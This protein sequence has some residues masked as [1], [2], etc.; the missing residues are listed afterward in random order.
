MIPHASYSDLRA[1]WQHNQ[2]FY[3]DL[4]RQMVAVNSFSLNPSGVNALGRLTA[5][6]F[7]PLGFQAE[8]IPSSDYRY[9]HHL[10]LTRA[11]RERAARPAP[12]IG[13]IS[14]LDTVFP[15]AEEQA[16]DFHFRIEGDRVYGP[17]TVDIKG[18]T[19]M[20]YMILDGLR[21]AFPH[22]YEGI[23]W[24]ILLNA[25]EEVLAP[26]F[27]RLGRE[28]L[29]GALAALV[30]EGGDAAD[31]GYKL[32]TARKGMARYRVRV[33]GRSA[34]AGTSHPKGANAIVQLADV[35]HAIAELTDHSREL[36][37]N[38]GTVAGGT[39]MN[40]VPHQAAASVEMRAYDQNVFE[41]G[42]AGMLALN[43]YCSVRSL[44][45][46]YPCQVEVE[47]EGRWSP[48][49]PNEATNR[50]VDVWAAAA[51]DLGLKIVSQ[52]RGGLSDGNWLWD[53]LPTL[54]GLGPQ[55]DNA[56]SSERS[57]D[58]SKEPE[59]VLASSFMPK[60]LLN[61]AAIV[62][63]AESAGLLPGSEQ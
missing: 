52:S 13:L 47:L 10:I 62:Q 28:R 37:F 56:H 43:D 2:S 16:N 41:E 59:Y 55:G 54:D 31:G 32:V 39:V 7:A 35:I 29:D 9:G 34:H 51:A 17:G 23:T 20:I 12:A 22:V 4:L 24:H 30:F 8:R 26:D 48:W 25:A 61:V 36:T 11:G 27:G 33:D 21:R 3:L 46:G 5:E 18:G 44:D 57:D 45:D 42:V 19:V 6:L 38:V 14:H 40:R 15:A 63:L 60:A 58:G 49:P 50:L 53:L 1:F